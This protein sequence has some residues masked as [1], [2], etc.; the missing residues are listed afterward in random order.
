[1]SL[2]A[3]PVMVTIL[4]LLYICLPCRMFTQQSEELAVRTCAV[5]LRTSYFPSCFIHA[6][7]GVNELHQDVL[8]NMTLNIPLMF[9]FMNLNL[10]L[11]FNN[12]VDIGA[13]NTFKR[14]K[15]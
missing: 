2:S 12:T 1:M 7:R 13:L 8:S 15:T 10:K 3:P 6:L 9:T 14:N 4:I 5:T 11:H